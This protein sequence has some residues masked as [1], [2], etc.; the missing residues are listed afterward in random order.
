MGKRSDYVVEKMRK[1]DEKASRTSGV[2]RNQEEYN[3]QK[4]AWKEAFDA[5]SRAEKVGAGR[6]VVNP[7]AINSKEQY[8]S[9]KEAGDPYASQMSYEDWKKL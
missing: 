3:A 8:L 1:A 9:E 4:K 5:Q 2:A 6:G 7:P